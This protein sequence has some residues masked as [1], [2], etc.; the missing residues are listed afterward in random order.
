M[1]NEKQSMQ[2]LTDITFTASNEITF[3]VTKIVTHCDSLNSR[4]LQKNKHT[5][6]GSSVS[7]ENCI[8]FTCFMQ[9]R[10]EQ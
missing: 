6:I 2:V 9:C 7:L 8:T 10:L 5:F 4:M 3:P 1:A